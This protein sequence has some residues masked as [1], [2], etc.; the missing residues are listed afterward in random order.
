MGDGRKGWVRADYLA[1]P[2]FLPRRPKLPV[3]EVDQASP[4][5]SRPRLE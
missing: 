3:E 2:V 1:Q 4:A 5:Q